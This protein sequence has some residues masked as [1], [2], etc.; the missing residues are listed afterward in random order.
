MIKTLRITS[1]MAAVLAVAFLVFLAVSGIHTDEQIEE[2]LNSAGVIEK[3]NKARGGRAADSKGQT[4]PLVK[5]AQAFGLYLNPPPAPVKRSSKK[6]VRAGLPKTRVSPP[7]V[8][9]K[10]EL[11][12]TSYYAR[13]P[14]LSMALINEPAKGFRWVRQ[15]GQVGHLFIDQIKDGL[16]VVK[17]GERAFELVTERPKRKS[18]VKGKADAE[19]DSKG[20][21]IPPDTSEGST[22]SRKFP[23]L[24]DERKELMDQ[25]MSR[26]QAAH[27]DFESDKTGSAPGREER[28]ARMKELLSKLQDTQISAEEAKKLD[29]LG[30]ELKDVQEDPNKVGRQADE[31]PKVRRRAE[32]R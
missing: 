18:L 4:P 5:Q 24:S 14:E 22:T 11:I 23:R 20:P 12:G 7:I 13:H 1:V 31:K 29:R 21:S 28:M 3:F 19:T 27:A 26:M 15:K 30:R 10:F 17:D 8:S 9:A 32:R 25:L 16:V 6:S 2:F